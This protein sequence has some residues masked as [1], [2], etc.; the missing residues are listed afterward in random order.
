MHEQPKKTRSEV[1]DMVL[2]EL[3]APPSR[4]ASRCG[5]RKKS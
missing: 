4:E 3:K 1:E 2:E 5:S